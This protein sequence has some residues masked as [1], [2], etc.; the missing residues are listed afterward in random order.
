MFV[1][2]KPL[3]RLCKDVSTVVLTLYVFEYESLVLHH[4]LSGIVMS[5]GYMS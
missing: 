2:S 1:E 5:E 4:L 3:Q